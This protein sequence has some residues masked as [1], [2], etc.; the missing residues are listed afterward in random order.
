MLSPTILLEHQAGGCTGTWVLAPRA[1]G[2]HW[3]CPGCGRIYPANVSTATRVAWERSLSRLI[4]ALAQRGAALVEHA[5]PGS[6][7]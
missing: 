7:E 2:F 3:R 6:R 5:R 4:D 1:E